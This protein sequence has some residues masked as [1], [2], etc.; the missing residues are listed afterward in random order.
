MEERLSVTPGIPSV[1]LDR[2]APVAPT[3]VAVL[4][5]STQCLPVVLLLSL[6]LAGVRPALPAR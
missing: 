1:V 6:P 3:L 5:L 4:M 2:V